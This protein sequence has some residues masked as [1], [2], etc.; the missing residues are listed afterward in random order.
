MKKQLICKYIAGSQSYGLATPTSDIDYRGVYLLDDVGMILDPYKYNGSS[1]KCEDSIKDGVDASYHELRHFLNI[2]RNCNTNA[3]EMMFNSNWELESQEW[4]LVQAEYLNLLDPQKFYK[5][6]KGY[7]QSETRL[8]IGERTGK[9]GGK[10]YEQVQK[11]G[12][13]PK[14]FVQLLRLTYAGS[15]FFRKGAFPLDMKDHKIHEKLMS[16]KTTPEKYRKEDLL[17]QVKY[18]ETVLDCGY[19]NHIGARS[20]QY[21]WNEEIATGIILKCYFPILEEAYHG[22]NTGLLR[23]IQDWF[24]GSRC[25]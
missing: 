18:W 11:Y 14:N 19:E 23:V 24:S 15:Y 2:L 10:R 8:A 25:M 3:V 6:L 17:Q 13:S 4:Q 7:I 20:T 5:A 22:K 12:F 16:I 1:T 21:K 9:L